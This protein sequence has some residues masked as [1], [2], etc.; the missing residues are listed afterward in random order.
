MSRQRDPFSTGPAAG[1]G[2]R[3]D[4]NEAHHGQAAVIPP[5]KRLSH[6][7]KSA[8]HAAPALDARLDAWLESARGP[9]GRAL[10]EFAWHRLLPERRVRV[11]PFDATWDR[12]RGQLAGRRVLV[13]SLVPP[14]DTGGGSRPAQLAAELHRRGCAIDW[15]WALPIFPWPSR[16]RPRIPGVEVRHVSETGL[17]GPADGR[18]PVHDLALL[19]APHPA[20]LAIATSSRARRL[21]YDAIDLWDGSLGAG[22]WTPGADDEAVARADLLLASSRLLR[23]DLAGRSGRP[24]A[25]L[26]TAV[27]P[28]RFDPDVVRPVPEDL[29]RGA[30]TVGYVGALWGDWVDL[31]LVEHAA[32][33]LPGAAFDLVGPA[34]DRR[35]PSASNVFALGPKVQADVPAYLAAFDVAIVPFATNRL[36]AAVSPLKAWEYLAMRRPVVSTPMP[37]LDGVP[38]VSFAGDAPGFARA[39]ERAAREPF[40]ADEVRDFLAH[41][42]W[43]A[44]VDEL[45]RLAGLDAGDRAPVEGAKD[46]GVGIPPTPPARA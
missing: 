30:P 25:L 16:R 42:T 27:D 9:L 39:I 15:R 40:P 2:E 14:E 23:D 5:H 32:R 10:R 24:V 28:R 21:A 17:P 36:T 7:L 1:G 6:R 38:G 44:R 33:L 20:L 31:D 11:S 8:V 45:C 22:W 37:D 12:D 3:A 18:G 34:G 19:E 35:L 26:P 13:L 29:H 43:S 41:H 4:S 46:T